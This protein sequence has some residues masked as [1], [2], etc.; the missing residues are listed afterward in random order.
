[1][2]VVDVANLQRTLAATPVADVTD[3]ANLQAQIN[4]AKVQLATDQLAEAN[5][6]EDATV[7]S[8][9]LVA[10]AKAKLDDADRTLKTEAVGTAAY[11][12]TLLEIRD[13]KVALAEAEAQSSQLA[14]AATTN[15]LDILGEARVVLNG[16]VAKLA[17]DRRSGASTD[18]INTDLAAVSD[19]TA[20]V[21]KDQVAIANAAQTAA[22]FPGDPLGTAQANLV[23]AQRSL[24]AD[25]VGTQQYYQDLATLKQAQYALAQATVQAQFVQSELG[26]DLTNP[27]AVAQAQ[28]TEAANALKAAQ[29]AGAPS[30]VTGPLQ[31]TADQAAA[32]AQKTAFEQQ[33]SDAQINFQLGRTSGAAYLNYL[34]SQHDLLSNIKDK[35][36]QQIDELND[37]DQAILAANNQLEGQFNIGNISVPTVFQVRSAVANGGIGSTDNSVTTVTINISGADSG[38]ITQITQALN[39]NPKAVVQTRKV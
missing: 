36:R 20:Q 22:V 25:L 12:Q 9:A 38:Q 32:N 35:T 1:V 27:V 17:A 21:I 3:R 10:G 24:A 16:A 19:A 28:A 26:I 7:Q 11:Y 31:V 15:P 34:E 4:Q 39:T 6:Q 13:D 2:D 30:S 23:N 37:V 33:L 29:A 18:T 8:G 14:A 5:A